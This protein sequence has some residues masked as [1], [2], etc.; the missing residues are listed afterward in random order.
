MIW[1]SIE[2][3]CFVEP[4]LPC[5]LVSATAF[6]NVKALAKDLPNAMSA[7]YLECRLGANASQIDFLTC[8]TAP[9]GGREIFAEHVMTANLPNAFLDKAL[10]QGFRNFFMHW[11]DPTSPLYR[12]VPLIWLEFDSVDKGLIEA[13]F[14]G[15]ILCL[16]PDISKGYKRVQSSTIYNRLKSKQVV[17]FALKCLLGYPVPN[18][19]KQQVFVCFDCLPPGGQIIHVGTML[20]R[21]PTWLNIYG[22]ISKEHLVEYLHQVGWNSSTTEIEKILTIFCAHTNIIRPDLS[23]N[24]RIWSRIAIEF[25]SDGT[26]QGDSKLQ[27]LLDQCVEN[28]LCTPEKRDALLSWSGISRKTFS[29][30]SWPVNLSRWFEIKIIY[31]PNYPIELKA[32]LGFRVNFSLF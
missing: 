11:A 15:L 23:I 32:Y 16:N 19:I 20:A 9:H 18:Q 24:D 6:S 17:E 25:S 2:T 21:Q 10:W 1:S 12:H 7:Y 31:Q 26:P 29:H 28:G 27:F 30:Q 5:E 13:P 4:Y 14:P 22:L 8:T 3:L